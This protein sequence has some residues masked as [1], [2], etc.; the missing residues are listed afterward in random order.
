MNSAASADL[1]LPG[2][3]TGLLGSGSRP[4][5]DRRRDAL[6]VESHVVRVCGGP[7]HTSHGSH[8]PVQHSCS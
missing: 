5:N 3:L 7:V 1:L 4:M 6:A 8:R 2:H